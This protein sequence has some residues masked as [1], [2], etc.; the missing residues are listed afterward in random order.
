MRY[1]V[2]LF[3]VGETLLGPVR[4]YGAVY[5]EVLRGEGLE[6]SSVELDRHI[7]DAAT[8]LTARI[9]S[10]VDRFGQFGG[11]EREYWRRFCDQVLIGATGRPLP[12]GT[13][14]LSALIDA[15]KDP[16]V[17]E[18]FPDVAPALAAL[19]ERGVRLGICSN[20]DSR[21]PALLERLDLARFFD[22]VG[23]SHLEGVEKPSPE[24][25]RR[26]LARLGASPEESLHVGD[27][28]EL[29]LEGARRAGLDGL[30]IDR[31]G[32]LGPGSGAVADLSGLP[33][34][35]ERGLEA[36]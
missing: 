9:P 10:G 11:D 17:W 32:R 12:D 33:R 1:P 35:A 15:F 4:S 21:L 5:R 18:V 2:V 26:V 27:L 28:P 25:F 3:D 8:R 7:R 16:A 14:V 36:R 29:D 24:L 30:L 6:L 23:V 20:W 34:I 31:R 22:A 13:R 19:R